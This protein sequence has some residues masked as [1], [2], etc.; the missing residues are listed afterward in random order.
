MA[1]ILHVSEAWGGGIVTAT[2]WVASQAPNHEHHLLYVP[3]GGVAR[4]PDPAIFAQSFEAPGARRSFMKEARRL[5][6]SPIYDVVHSH[7]SW[8]GAVCRLMSPRDIAQ[9][10]SPHCFAFERRDVN[11]ST[12]RIFRAVESMAVDSTDLIVANGSFEAALAEHVG[13]RH[14]LDLPMIGHPAPV[15][16]NN[17][18]PST[19]RVVT[20]GRVAPQK[21]PNYFVNLVQ[22]LRRNLDREVEAVW[23]G[24]PD[25]SGG[26]DVLAANNVVVTGWL[27][28]RAVA[29]ELAKASCYVHTA[30]WEAGA[31]LAMLDAA[32]AG[33]PVVARDLPCLSWGGFTSANSLVD[34]AELVQQISTISRVRD[35]VL[36]A[37]ASALRDL[38]QR[39]GVIDLDAAYGSASRL[40]A[41]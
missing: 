1:L 40:L 41:A 29:A 16:V 34:H 31:P 22:I 12:R 20:L 39:A 15:V 17:S 13:H 25:V 18:D 32:R 27:E 6:R 28:P 10:Y 26:T 14:V 30:A 8:A 21:D 4:K 33:V 35:E 24:A 38:Q 7:S 23:I 2:E 11:A 19:V 37:G 9:F 5:M 3:R 36:A